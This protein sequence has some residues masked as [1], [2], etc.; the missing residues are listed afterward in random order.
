MI[1][2]MYARYLCAVIAAS[3]FLVLAGPARTQQ[4]SQAALGMAKE[5][6]DIVGAARE[7]EPL[8][9]GVIV[10]T[11]T[12]FLQAN[13]AISKDLND[14]VDLMVTEFLPRRAEIPNEIVRLYAMRLT[15]QELKDALVFYK[16]PLGKKMLTESQFILGETFKR[17]DTWAAKFREEV[18]GRIRAELKKKGHNL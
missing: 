16:S 10:Q 8:V 17:A 12:T 4:P 18:A 1:A 11:A 3:V 9:T 5:L 7:F 2:A 6:V 15:E 13:P 14:I